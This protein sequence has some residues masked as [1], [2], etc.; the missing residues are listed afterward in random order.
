MEDCKRHA[1]TLTCFRLIQ[2]VLKLVEVT[3]ILGFSSSGQLFEV[4]H[5]L[6]LIA[7]MKWFS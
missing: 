1:K 7:S 2:C 6:R 4:S 5:H 3:F